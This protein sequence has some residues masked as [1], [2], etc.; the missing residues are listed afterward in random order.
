MLMDLIQIVRKK[1]ESRKTPLL[2]GLNNHRMELSST[3]GV[4]GWGFHLDMLGLRCVLDTPVELMNRQ[5]IT[6]VRS[7]ED[8]FMLG[9]RIGKHQ[10]RNDIKNH[11]TGS[12]HKRNK[13]R[14]KREET[15]GLSPYHPQH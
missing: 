1:E 6:G 14:Q 8:S 10:R 4:G 7:S 9:H 11:E 5:F 13:C 15:Q 3:E 12:D 2:F